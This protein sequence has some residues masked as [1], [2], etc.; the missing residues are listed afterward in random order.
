MQSM[1]AAL[2]PFLF[3]AGQAF[4]TVDNSMSFVQYLDSRMHM[5]CMHHLK[6]VHQLSSKLSGIQSEKDVANYI[7]YHPECNYDDALMRGC[8]ST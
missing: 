1:A 2:Y 7:K 8:R 3:P 5:L 6:L 4:H